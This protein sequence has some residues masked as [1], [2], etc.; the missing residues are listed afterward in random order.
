[1][2]TKNTSGQLSLEEWSIYDC[3]TDKAY[4]I[5][6]YEY[7]REVETIKALY[8]S[9]KARKLNFDEAGNWEHLYR[10]DTAPR[11]AMGVL[12]EYVGSLYL[13]IPPTFPKPYGDHDTGKPSKRL[14]ALPQTVLLVANAEKERGQYFAE[15]ELVPKSDVHTVFINWQAP[16][17]Y[18]TKAF[19]QWLVK[20]RPRKAK[21]FPGKAGI[22][23]LIK[24]FLKALSVYRLLQKMTIQDAIALVSQMKEEGNL[25]DIL[26]T[27]S[28][29]WSKANTLAKRIIRILTT[30]LIDLQ[31]PDEK[32]FSRLLVEDI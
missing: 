2:A 5:F 27:D 14:A 11:G 13:N 29:D 25:T 30:Q 19:K 31:D 1:M 22:P 28:S 17:E 16:D 12:Q 26:Y 15:N 32:T 6:C 20:N 24:K 9:D 3:D 23:V 10:I 4:F 7:A 8:Q 18:L 21:S